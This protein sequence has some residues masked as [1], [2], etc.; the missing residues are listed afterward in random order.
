MGVAE[1]ASAGGG[2][3]PLVSATRGLQGMQS[4]TQRVQGMS[5]AR[6]GVNWEGKGKGFRVD[7]SGVSVSLSGPSKKALALVRTTAAD[8]EMVALDANC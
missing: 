6:V 4:R 2:F 8:L 3:C 7:P 1:S 5:P